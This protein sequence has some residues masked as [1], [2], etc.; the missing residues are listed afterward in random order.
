[1]HAEQD[2][3]IV[4]APR[5]QP[6][7]VAAL[8]PRPRPCR[9]P[10]VRGFHLCQNSERLSLL[11]RRHRGARRIMATM[12]PDQEASPGA[13]AAV[14]FSAF[15][16]A[17]ARVA[18]LSFGGPAGQIAVMHRLLVDER[19]WIS[20]GR[21]V[22]ALNYCMLLPGPEAQQ[23]AT[24]IG[25]L[26]RGTPGGLIAGG[27]FVL[28]G[29]LGMLLFS[30]LYAGYRQVPAVESLFLGVKAAVLAVVVEAVL[31]IGRRVLKNPWMHAI[32]AA[33]FTGIFFLDLPF[34]LIVL[35]AAL[36]GM[37]LD[38]WRPRVVASA[39][40]ASAGADALPA[41]SAAENGREM[42]GWKSHLMR[43]GTVW[44]GVWL[45]PVV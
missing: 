30:L 5:G 15:F 24:Y 42:R 45:L 35:A 44:L 22:H 21:F 7:H 39:A 2:A 31:R 12:T 14:P 32:A 8:R 26:M 41:D 19:R 25:W 27:L 38:R 6:F 13:S 4:V 43:V 16:L 11:P 23:L 40:P 29:F 28:P 18:V 36:A 10:S 17:W 9:H 37:A 20:E 1:V 33:A 3:G 34:P